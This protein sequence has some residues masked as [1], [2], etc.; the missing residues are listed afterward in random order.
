ME[1]VILVLCNVPDEQVAESMAQALVSKK[2]AACVNVLPAVRSFYQWQGQDESSTENTLLMKTA[3]AC[4]AALQAE[5]VRL[6]PYETPEI[7]A[8][9]IVEGLPAYLQWVIQETKSS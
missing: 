7:I 9:P 1:Q 2:L 6:H 8:V 5:V 4:Y 3:K